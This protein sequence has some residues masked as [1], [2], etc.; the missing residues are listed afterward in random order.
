[1]LSLR[2]S[3]LRRYRLFAPQLF[4]RGLLLLAVLLLC[5]GIS[6]LCLPQIRAALSLN[7]PTTNSQSASV[8]TPAVTFMDSQPVLASDD[9][10]RADQ[11]YWGISPSGQPWQAD[12]QTAHSFFIS[13][14]KGLVSATAGFLCGVLGPVVTNS[15]VRFAASLSH[16]GAS[17][18]GAILRWDSPDDFY[19]VVLDGHGLTLSRVMDGM[20]IPLGIVP[21]TPRDGASYT[22]L[23]R[24]SGSQLSAVIWPTGQPAPTDWQISLSDSALSAGRDGIG[25]L[26]QAGIQ[27]Q[28]SD[29]KEVQL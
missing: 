24:A 4:R 3:L 8:A 21:I 7:S 5:D 2:R 27:A 23:F 19:K 10:E 18:L 22:F 11:S 14:N 20:E 1:M 29:F 28:V 17:G 25:V 13:G 12:A 26:V 9:F 15:E 6:A 16:Y